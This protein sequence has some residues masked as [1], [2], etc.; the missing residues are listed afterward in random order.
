MRECQRLWPWRSPRQPRRITPVSVTPGGPPAC[1]PRGPNSASL[2]SRPSGS[3]MVAGVP[4]STPLLAGC[5]SWYLEDIFTLDD[6]TYYT[7]PW[8]WARDY[9]WH[10]DLTFFA[11]YNCELQTGAKGG[12]TPNLVPEPKD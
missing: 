1:E 3:F 5:D 7:R 10:P 11:E 2:N 4:P 12:L 9:A 8:S 6:P